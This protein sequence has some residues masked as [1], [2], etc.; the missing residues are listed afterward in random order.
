MD[1]NTIMI[2]VSALL[3]VSEA[4]S[5]IPRIKSNGVFQIAV[6]VLKWLSTKPIKKG[7]K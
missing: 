2:V 6:N 5:F 7:G 3:A 4:L 1:I